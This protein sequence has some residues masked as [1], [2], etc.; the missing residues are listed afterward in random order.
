MFMD[1]LG[2]QSF[3]F[4]R[5]DL[6]REIVQLEFKVR[7]LM[8]HFLEGNYRTPDNAVERDLTSMM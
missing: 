8:E 1:V 3:N 5:V 6:C 7:T 4:L 2:A